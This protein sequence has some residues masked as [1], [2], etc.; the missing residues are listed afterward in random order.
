MQY[1]VIMYLDQNNQPDG[2]FG[3]YVNRDPIIFIFHNQAKQEALLTRLAPSL[4]EGQKIGAV[5]F[6]AESIYH[7][8]RDLLEMDPS[9]AGAANFVPDS[10]QL[11]AIIMAELD[12]MN[13]N[14]TKARKIEA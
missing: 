6:E 10:A 8:V 1:S 11:Y 3:V 9:L 7:L 2:F 12:Q 5:S 14:G 13:V 4:E